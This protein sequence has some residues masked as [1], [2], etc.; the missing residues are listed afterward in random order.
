MLESEPRLPVELER[1][2]FELAATSHTPLI[3]NYL[4]VARRVK[5][6]L[7]PILYSVVVFSDPLPGHVSFDPARL[8][9]AVQSPVIS[10]YV[11]N[12]CVAHIL[13]RSS[14]RHLL[15][16]LARCSSIRN[17]VLVGNHSDLLPSLSALPLRRLSANLS[18]AFPSGI[19]FTH[20]VFSRITHL[21]SFDR[22]HDAQ[23]E[24]WRGL[25]AIPNLTHLAFQRQRN[26]WI[27]PN[28]LSACRQVQVLIHLESR[29]RTPEIVP[30]SVI[31]ALAHDTRF[32]SMPAPPITTDWQIG[33]RGGEDFLD[34]CR[35]L[36]C[37]AKFW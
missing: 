34:P 17:L 27:Y 8:S 12:L 16:I 32:V 5:I 15:R 30:Q 19:D 31:D 24:E 33:A 6:W 36:Y 21:H 2:I 29:L 26:L 4:L 25:A 11:E 35:E 23:W 9:A 1:Q 13:V 18:K 20:P 14:L 28:V 3:P 37:Q 7:E 10:Q 22:L